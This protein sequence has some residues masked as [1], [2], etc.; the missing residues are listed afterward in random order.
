MNK[1]EIKE[2]CP[3]LG[4]HEKPAVMRYGGLQCRM[5]CVE[6]S[7]GKLACESNTMSVVQKSR[8][9]G[10]FSWYTHCITEGNDIKT[11]YEG[12]RYTFHELQEAYKQLQDSGEKEE[13]LHVR[14]LLEIIH[15]YN[16]KYHRD[17]DVKGNIPLDDYLFFTDCVLE[18]ERKG[19]NILPDSLRADLYR[20][21]GMFEK[22]FEFSASDCRTRDEKEI[23][24]E[25][26][27]RAAHGDSKP[28]II[29]QCEYY[30]NN[31]R[32]TKRFPCQ[33]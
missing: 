16:D 8:N 29:E 13:R 31:M 5:Q 25:V 11:E 2:F 28:F 21:I 33:M 15:A 17:T 7:D 6:W 12:K 1:D 27:F 10:K 20:Q 19:K 22:C 3:G 30:K 14:L 26:L 23:V 9:T 4:S 32:T 18:I 24:D